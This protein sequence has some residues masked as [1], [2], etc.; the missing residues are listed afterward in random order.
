M[1]RE[2]FLAAV[3]AALALVGCQRPEP[4]TP[5]AAAAPAAAHATAMSAVDE[6]AA[7]TSASLA[8]VVNDADP[9]PALLRDPFVLPG[10]FAPDTALAALQQRYGKANVQVGDVPG[11]E[12]AT[13]RGVLLFPNDPSRLAYLYFQDE[14]TLAGL[15]MVR[16][17]GPVS[18]WKLDNGIGIGTPLSELLRRNGRPIRFYGFEWDYGGTITDWKGGKL[19]PRDDNP[20]RHFLSLGSRKDADD[21]TYPV[22]D[23]EY[24]S[25]DPRYP[26]LA[27]NVVVNEIGVSFPGEDDL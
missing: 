16:V 3:L 5:A 24:S 23:S 17:F 15:S 13:A 26:E 18:Q 6:N 9:D 2:V 10:A 11:A 1:K 27:N 20:V 19:A 21:G 8:G 7:R 22:G 4:G 14:K 12:G 25:D